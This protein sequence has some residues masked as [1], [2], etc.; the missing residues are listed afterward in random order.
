MFD[1]I[2]ILFLSSISVNNLIVKCQISVVYQKTCQPNIMTS[3]IKLLTE[4][5]SI[6][7][8]KTKSN[9]NDQ[10]EIVETW[11]VK[12]KINKK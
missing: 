7:N 6:T 11:R 2:F 12:K 8:M 5:N 4:I 1:F 10:N 9:M 3:V